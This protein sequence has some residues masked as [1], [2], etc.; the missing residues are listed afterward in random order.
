M[1]APTRK[2]HPSVRK[3]QRQSVKR[4][5]RNQAIKSRA[6]TFIKKV[7]EAL[8]KKDEAT[9]IVQLQGTTRVLYKAV[10]KGVLH[11]NTV[12]RRVSRLAKRVHNL[13]TTLAGSEGAQA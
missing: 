13:K 7:Q 10:S 8:A 6:K 9:A 11:R 1:A 5:L 3:R 4:H 12:A 2:K